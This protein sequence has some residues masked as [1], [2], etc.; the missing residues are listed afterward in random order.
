[1]AFGATDPEII[2]SFHILAMYSTDAEYWGSTG[3]AARRCGVWGVSRVRVGC[4]THVNVNVNNVGRTWW[5]Y[6]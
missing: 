3:A 4:R 1:M 6:L 2:V 5:R